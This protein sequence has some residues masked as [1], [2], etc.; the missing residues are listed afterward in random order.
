M[1]L[2]S[3]ALPHV[4]CCVLDNVELPDYVCLCV[5]VVESQVTWPIQQWAFSTMAICVDLCC[6][7]K[8]QKPRAKKVITLQGKQQLPMLVDAE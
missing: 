2:W 8:T 7:A 6:H 3:A 5:F 1:S 4:A